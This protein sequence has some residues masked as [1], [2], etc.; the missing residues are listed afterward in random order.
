MKK[1]ILPLLASTLVAGA[2]DIPKGFHNL[3]E[4][5]AAQ[6]EAV[7]NGEMIA[8]LLTDPKLQPS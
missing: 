5:D 8:F 4:L 1:L 7:K 6:A 3:S 2:F